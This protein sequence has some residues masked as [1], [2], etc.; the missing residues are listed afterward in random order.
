MP[1]ETASDLPEEHLLDL[2]QSYYYTN[3]LVTKQASVE[4]KTRNQAGDQQWIIERSKRITASRIGSIVKMTATT[5]KSKRVEE[6]LY[7][8]F[9][10]NAATRYGS[11]M[12]SVSVEEYLEYQRRKGHSKLCVSKS[13]LVIS[14]TH[15]WLGASPDGFVYDPDHAECPHGILEIKNPFR[16]REKSIDEACESSGFCLEKKTH[17]TV[18][19]KVRHDYYFQIQCQLFCTQRN[20]CDFVVRTNKALFVE[21]IEKNPEWWQQHIKTAKTFYFDTLLAELACPRYRKGG[22]R[23]HVNFALQ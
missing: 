10:G 12:E 2:M 5:K 16:D 23:E 18:R 4:L 3:V 9:K 17:D 22:S 13:G 20:W 1:E 15:P 14:D 19:L 8:T 21:R 11:A 6:L 7:N